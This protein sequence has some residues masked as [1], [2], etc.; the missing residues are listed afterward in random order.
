[1][2]RPQ[3]EIIIH[4]LSNHVGGPFMKRF[5]A[6]LAVLV[7]GA[8]LSH[9]DYVIVR[10]NL[11][12]PPPPKKDDK[13][14]P[15]TYKGLYPLKGPQ[16]PAV[17]R[18]GPISVIALIEYNRNVAIA[19]PRPDQWGI[20]HAWGRTLL[21]FDQKTI[22]VH[23]LRDVYKGKQVVRLTPPQIYDGRYQKIIFNKAEP[24]ASFLDLAQWAL[25]N[26]LEAKV[27]EL[28]KQVADRNAASAD[29]TVTKI[30][31]AYNKVNQQMDQALSRDELF[32][33]AGS[34]KLNPAKSEHYSL[35]YDAP[36]GAPEIDSRLKKLEQNY[37]SFFWWFALR[38]QALPVPDKRL[39][40]LQID[41]PDRFQEYQQA[42]GAE[43]ATDSFYMQR[44]NLVVFSSL[45]LDQPYELASRQFRELTNMGW[46]L[47]RLLD[48]RKAP[49]GKTVDDIARAQTLALIQKKLHEESE[50]AS[51][52]QAG[53][54]QLLTATGLLPRTVVL[55]EWIQVGLASFFESPKFSHESLTGS[56][57]VTCGAPHWVYHALWREEEDRKKLP[58]PA[59]ALLDVVSDRY[60]RTAVQETQQT[61]ARTMAWSL[62]YFLAHRKLEAL[63]AYCRELGTLPRDLEL[64]DEVYLGCF[65]RAF[66]LNGGDGKL[67][68][69]KVAELAEEWYK[70]LNIAV[71]PELS[72]DTQHALSDLRKK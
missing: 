20:D 56:F 58:E 14:P 38:G 57:W 4:F 69:A 63:L 30:L 44:Q 7:A 29:P 39:V 71:L 19:A 17:V 1:V 12:A 47:R 62:T 8:S 3:N 11:G 51:V 46:D 55:P 59:K 68:Q 34:L 41:R 49:G 22:Q 13:Q 27:P 66:G 50:I 36:T 64:S 18:V 31:E 37:R 42:F 54:R 2:A 45:P 65:A 32:Y 6:A 21:M 24:A 5:V 60:F 25:T 23:P 16:E 28:M 52:S 33:D 48:I 26:G 61:K 40:A 15:P 10:M 53:T 70:F 43:P 67:D 35:W 9:A 72:Q